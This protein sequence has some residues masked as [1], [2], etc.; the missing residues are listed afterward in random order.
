MQF[1]D[2]LLIKWCVIWGGVVYFSRKS[3]LKV[4]TVNVPKELLLLSSPVL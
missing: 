3:V 4:S 2:K 1:W